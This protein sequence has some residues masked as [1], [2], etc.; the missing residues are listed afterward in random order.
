MCLSVKPSKGTSKMGTIQHIQ[1]TF[2]EHQL[3]VDAI[4]E[5][6]DNEVLVCIVIVL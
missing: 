1:E 6:D 5:I 3:S 2:K 4:Y